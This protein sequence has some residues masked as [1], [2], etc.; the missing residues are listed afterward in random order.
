MLSP[1]S[2]AAPDV[3]IELAATSSSTSGNISKRFTT[4]GALSF[5]FPRGSVFLAKD[6]GMLAGL[7]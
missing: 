1:S 3:I 2:W 5:F 4:F 7:G 6:P